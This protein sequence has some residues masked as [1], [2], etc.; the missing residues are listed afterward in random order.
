MR[1][2][3]L[4]TRF[5]AAVVLVATPERVAAWQREGR[6]VRDMPPNAADDDLHRHF[7]ADLCLHVLGIPVDAVFTG[8]AY[9]DGFAA[10]LS[11]RFAAVGAG[12]VVHVAVARPEGDDRVSGTRLRAD[13]HAHRGDLAPEVYA[14]FVRRV[15]LLGGE[16]S[17]KSTLAA[18]LAGSLG[19]QHVAEYGRELWEARGGA[20]AYDDL[21]RIARAQVEREEAALPHAAR[22]LVCDTSPLTT[23]LYSRHLFGRAEPELEAL[24]DRR[25]AAVLLCAPD[26][27]FVQDGTRQDAAFREWQHRWYLGELAARGWPFTLLTGTLDER[28]AQATS[29]IVR[30]G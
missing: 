27:P 2:R 16:A 29:A 7:T 26:F 8:E 1:E 11:T 12:P 25:Y 15:C 13:V 21:L 4:R 30:L 18:A 10:V 9:G 24:A 14:S 20:L 19:T 6:P 17:G 22:V 5:P 28:I 23:L 3:W